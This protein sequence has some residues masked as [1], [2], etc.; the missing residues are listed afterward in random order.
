VYDSV[1]DV[2]TTFTHRLDATFAPVKPESDAAAAVWKDS[3]SLIGGPVTT[4]TE[5]PVVIGPPLAGPGWAATDAC[6]SPGPHRSAMNP[7]GGRINGSER[8]AIDWTKAK[9]GSLA[10]G[11]LTK[12]EKWATYG[13][14]LLAV[15][16]GTV[17]KVVSDMPDIVPGVPPTGLK[18]NEY[19]G[20]VVIIGIGDRVYASYAHMMR[21]SATV[22]VGDKVSKGQVIGRLGNSGNTFAPHLHFQLQRTPAFLSGDAVPYEIDPLTFVG[23]LDL[24]SFVV[25]PGPHAGPR[26]NQ[27]PLRQ[28]IVDF[29]AAR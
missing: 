7:V 8:F 24:Q 9:D 29:P 17:V 16:D 11:D 22:K 3:D 26:T 27:M 25:I 1:A 14:P 5:S 21:A 19:P 20:N 18:I 10:E 23:S 12:L 15:A 13:E 4:S 6:C 28:N 2:P